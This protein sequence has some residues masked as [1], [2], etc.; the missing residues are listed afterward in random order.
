MRKTFI[1]CFI[2]IFLMASAAN[3]KPTV[4]CN[5]NKIAQ[6]KLLV[7]FTWEITVYS[8][9]NWQVCELVISFRDGKGDEIYTVQDRLK[10]KI[11]P[12]SF[13]GHEICDTKIWGRIKKYVTT[14]DCVF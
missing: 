13:M 6:H 8:D 2:L 4:K 10:L 1:F 14:L 7:T 12:N 9:K 11:G 5:I 3:A